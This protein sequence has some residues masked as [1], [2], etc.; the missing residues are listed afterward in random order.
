MTSNEAIRSA[1]LISAT[2]EVVFAGDQV[3][4]AGQVDYPAAPRPT[5]GYPLMFILQ[6]AGCN[7]REY[8]N[9]LAVLALASGY[10][11]FRWDKR[12]TGRSGASGRGSTTQDAVY[13]YQMAL[14]QDNID[15]HYITILAEGAGSGLLGSSFG[16]F[17]RVQLPQQVILLSN[18]L[19]ADAI[20]A[21][22]A[23]VRIILHEED[24]NSWEVYGEAATLAHNRAYRHGAAY[25]VAPRVD[26][27]PVTAIDELRSLHS[28]IQKVLRDWL[29]SA[30]PNS[31]LV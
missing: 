26:P 21:L 12:G 1:S 4:L 2:R 25:Y 17:A 9:P 28:G 11:V 10:A 24:W 20:V 27:T 16:L 7:T 31:A 14:D 22:D 23:P 19:D 18:Q 5:G 3:L 8:Y 6:H 13:A 29:T 30:H 15:P